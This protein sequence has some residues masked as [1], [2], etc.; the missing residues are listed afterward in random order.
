MHAKN[1]TNF[2][3][4]ELVM[5]GS[6]VRK[7]LPK[8]YLLISQFG[9]LESIP[10]KSI[11]ALFMLSL[12]T[13]TLKLRQY[14]H[15]SFTIPMHCFCFALHHNCTRAPSKTGISEQAW[16][17]PLALCSRFTCCSVSPDVHLGLLFFYP[18][19]KLT[20]TCGSEPVGIG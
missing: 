19:S 9:P 13:R 5:F 15:H 18:S 14:R 12:H 7:A 6:S 1:S 4:L 16:R 20:Q 10:S 17:E 8:F 2:E 11:L 3:R